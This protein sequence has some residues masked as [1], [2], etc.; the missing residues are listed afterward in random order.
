MIII[1][2]EGCLLND[3][4]YKPNFDDAHTISRIGQNL[5]GVFDQKQGACF[6]NNFHCNMCDFY[7]VVFDPNVAFPNKW[8]KKKYWSVG[9]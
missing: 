9:G 4:L 5:I 6:M 2:A 1:L 7:S 3:L 8:F